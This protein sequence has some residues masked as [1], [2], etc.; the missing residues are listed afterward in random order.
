MALSD[1]PGLAAHVCGY[2]GKSLAPAGLMVA[3]YLGQDGMRLSIK[4]PLV[5][6]RKRS[7]RWFEPS[8]T[9]ASRTRADETAGG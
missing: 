9:Q 5:E 6:C 7:T 2:A 1:F 3:F 4:L 8:Y